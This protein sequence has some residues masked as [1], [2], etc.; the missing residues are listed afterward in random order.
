MR[1]KE[2]TVEAQDWKGNADGTA[3]SQATDHTLEEAEQYVKGN[4]PFF[5]KYRIS[6]AEP[7]FRANLD[8]RQYNRSHA[9]VTDVDSALDYLQLKQ[10]AMMSGSEQISYSLGYSWHVHENRSSG[11]AILYYQDRG[12]GWDEI[13]IAAKDKN[14]LKSAVQLFRD[15]GVIATPKPRKPREPP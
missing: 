11:I 10:N 6:R 15:A 8:P 13:I 14:N 5:K 7:G 12:M 3:Q 2:F 1:A 9:Q 4:Y